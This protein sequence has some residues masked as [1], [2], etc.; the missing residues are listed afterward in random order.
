[1]QNYFFQ[2][3]PFLAPYVEYYFVMEDFFTVQENRPAE[4][5]KVF[6][7][8][9]C[10]MVFSYGGFVRE[11]WLGKAPKASP[12]YAIGGYAT[13]SVEYFPEG[14]GGFIMVGFKPWGI[15]CFIDFEVREIT[16]ANSDM[17]LHFGR[18][19][20]F[21]EEKLREAGNIAERIRIIEAFLAGKI[22]RHRPD[23]AMIHA[24]EL[25]TQSGGMMPVEQLARQCFM[26]RRQFLR[27]FEAGIGINPK[28]FSRIVR[29]Q[30][31]F[32]KM[33]NGHTT[34]DWNVIAFE[35]GYFD[36]AH[37]INEF[38]EFSG[39]SPEQFQRGLLRN[40][41]GPYLRENKEQPGHYL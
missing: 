17:T 4:G 33:T 9:H 12:G 28:T 36:Q 14:Q 40:P 5:L 34:P 19:V 24:V 20:L 25:V 32:Q 11:R 37:F 15:Q 29:F 23:P 18:E 10:E 39:Y 1:M 21:V 3:S 2:P 13:Q 6:P 41:P 27:R 26:S 16:N 7:A 8:P 35:A 22:H 38:R 30:Q 31:A